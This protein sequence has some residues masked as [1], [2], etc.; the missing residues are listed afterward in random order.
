MVDVSEEKAAASTLTPTSV[1]EGILVV[2]CVDLVQLLA[3]VHQLSAVVA[4]E[5]RVGLSLFIVSLV[6]CFVPS[7]STI[8][9]SPVGCIRSLPRQAPNH[10]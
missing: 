4:K 2:R 10:H 8:I 7:T 1:L 5:P 3:A 6:A 9:C